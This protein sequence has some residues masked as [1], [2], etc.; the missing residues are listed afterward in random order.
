[1][2]KAGMT[3]IFPRAF[4]SSVTAAACQRCK[5]ALSAD[6]VSECPL[7]GGDL[8][9][10]SGQ[11]AAR[12]AMASLGASAR[13]FWQQHFPFSRANGHYASTQD[14][15]FAPPPR[16]RSRYVLMAVCAVG[17]LVLAAIVGDWI[18]DPLSMVNRP[19]HHR[20]NEPAVSANLGVVAQVPDSSP[21]VTAPAQLDLNGSGGPV[22]M[23]LGA[24][25]GHNLSLARQRLSNAPA[26]Q[27]Y[28]SEY[29]D[30]D[31]K[32]TRLEAARD[33]A[34]HASLACAKTNSWSCVHA[35]ADK[36]AAIDVGSEEAAALSKL[37]SNWSTKTRGANRSQRAPAVA[38]G[39]QKQHERTHAH[40]STRHYEP[41]RKK[42]DA[43][44][45]EAKKGQ[46]R[47]REMKKRETRKLVSRKP[48]PLPTRTATRTQVATKPPAP[49]PAPIIDWSP[50]VS[51]DQPIPPRSKGRGEAH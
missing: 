24:L 2:E 19:T 33:A 22:S 43:R 45:P 31:I 12:N 9:A 35:N 40:S 44:K 16:R 7:C 48:A 29:R 6:G 30:A 21:A 49:P 50:S 42:A 4:S 20:S 25:E 28:S 38:P 5:S 3:R 27:T 41:A 47:K 37:S 34:L 1:M 14:D 51:A 23:A 10:S 32:L 36:A 8:S 18:M 39:V 46:S 13:R 15:S 26:D 17:G 11:P